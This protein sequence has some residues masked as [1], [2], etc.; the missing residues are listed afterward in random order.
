MK[1]SLM[2][3]IPT[4]I[5]ESCISCGLCISRCPDVF[6]FNRDGKSIVFDLAGA[7]REKIQ[8]AIDGC[9]VQCVSWQ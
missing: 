7:L 2:D 1:G 6:R 5:Q 8:Q 3:S 4:V 9:P